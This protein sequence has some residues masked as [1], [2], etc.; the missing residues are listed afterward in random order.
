MGEL[1][2]LLGLKTTSTTVMDGTAATFV[3]DVALRWKEEEEGGRR[4]AKGKRKEENN[5]KW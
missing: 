5:D 4:K 2:Q 1:V 3:L